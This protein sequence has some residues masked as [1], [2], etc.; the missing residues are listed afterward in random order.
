LLI[1]GNDPQTVK[2][3]LL[4]YFNQQGINH[5]DCWLIITPKPRQ[6]PSCTQSQSPLAVQSLRDSPNVLT[7][8]E[9]ILPDN[10]PKLGDFGLAWLSIDP[11]VLQVQF[12]QKDPWWI[13]QSYSSTLPKDKQPLS[14]NPAAI[15]GNVE[16]LQALP[17]DRLAPLFVIA[18][19]PYLPQQNA[20]ASPSTHWFVTAQD[21]AIQ[22]SPQQGWH[23]LGEAEDWSRLSDS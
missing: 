13:V 14:G 15:I 7:L 11:V 10:A 8:T 22:W 6:S 4:P 9:P 2:F 1:N 23:P 17:L 21:G 12:Q 5:L 19:A 18:I 3:S 20:I 16:S